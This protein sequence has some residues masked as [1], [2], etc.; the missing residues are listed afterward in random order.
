MTISGK[1]EL[2]TWRAR[3]GGGGYHT[4]VLFSIKNELH[5]YVVNMISGD[6][7]LSIENMTSYCTTEVLK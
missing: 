7:L 2:S 3:G 5:V 1:K 6:I 4:Q